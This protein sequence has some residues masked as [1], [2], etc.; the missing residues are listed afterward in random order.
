MTGHSEWDEL[1]AGYALHGLTAEDEARFVGH[2]EN[3]TECAANIKDFD[4]VAAQLGSIAHYPE[5]TAE[6]PTWESLR[7]AIV[8]DAREHGGVTD[9]AGRRRRRDVLARRSLAAAA[10]VVVLVGGGVATWQLTTGGGSDCSAADGCHRVELAAAG[11]NTAASLVIRGQRVSMTP[12][13][14]MAPAPAGKTYRS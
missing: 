2:L 12:T 13:S 4:F 8:G 6:P 3:C 1:A 5:A 7:T 10:G 14:V 9:L 11:G